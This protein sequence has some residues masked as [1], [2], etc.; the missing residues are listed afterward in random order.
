MSFNTVPLG[1]SSVTANSFPA[2]VVNASFLH[3][4]WLASIH[5]CLP[6]RPQ[7]QHTKRDPESSDKFDNFLKLALLTMAETYYK[8]K[9]IGITDFA[10]ILHAKKNQTKT[11]QMTQQIAFRTLSMYLS[12]KIRNAISK[13]KQKAEQTETSDLYLDNVNIEFP[14]PPPPPLP[15]EAEAFQIRFSLAYTILLNFGFDGKSHIMFS[16]SHW[17]DDN[18]FDYYPGCASTEIFD[19]TNNIC[20]PIICEPGHQVVHGS[21][22]EIKGEVP[23]PDEDTDSMEDPLRDDIINMVILKA[24]VTFSDFL[25]AMTPDFKVMMIESLSKLL[26][27]SVDRIQNFTV[28]KSETPADPADMII[29]R[30]PTKNYKMF[31]IPEPIMDKYSSTNKTNMKKEEKFLMEISFILMPLNTTRDSG[32]SVS[33]IIEEM[34]SLVQSKDFLLSI[35]ETRVTVVGLRNESHADMSY[36]W[37]KNGI[38]RFFNDSQFSMVSIENHGKTS[39]MIYINETNRLYK[40]GEFDLTIFVRSKIGYNKANVTGF[41]FVCDK[42]HIRNKKCGRISLNKGEYILYGNKSVNFR[43]HTL[44][45][46]D[47]QLSSGGSIVICIPSTMKVHGSMIKGCDHGNETLLYTQ[48]ILTIVFGILSLIA[49]LAVLITYTL[50]SKLRNIPGI[51]MMNLTLAL[52]GADLIFLVFSS[53]ESDAVCVTVAVSLHYLFLASFFWMNVMSYDLFRTFGHINVLPTP[54][55]KSKVIPRYLLYAWGAPLCIVAM[56]LVIEFGHIFPSV[57]IGYGRANPT[58]FF[59]KNLTQGSFNQSLNRTYAS[60]GTPQTSHQLGCWIQ[61]PSASLIAFGIP[62][63]IIILSNVVMFIRTIYC[64][65]RNLKTIHLN[66][67]HPVSGRHDVILYVRMSVVMGFTWVL[68][69]ASS[70][71]SGGANPSDNIC[72]LLNILGIL[73]VIFNCS[74]GI[75]ICSVFVLNRRV[76]GLYKTLWAKLL[77]TIKH[78]D[79][80]IFSVST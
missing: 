6:S 14:P 38:K 49:L 29:R 63:S 75:F 23:P 52:F 18:Y 77:K 55:Q 32:K 50:F 71:I 8:K 79:P 41:V 31:I 56:C 12:R 34:D 33:S 24:N 53:V 4:V 68:G 17:E 1:S 26:N 59:G 61:D 3:C 45:I 28:H 27:T 65:R 2:P 51:N 11:Y 60:M 69:F 46:N 13:E 15:Q 30:V 73:F 66:I 42:P 74:Q 39:E 72:L 70:G 35:N 62:L 54:R 48:I 40:K 47:Y 80:S 10:R 67:N 78:R 16:D 57:S 21:C 20:R 36:M 58:G 5:V 7:N 25:T 76:F 9:P 37:C 64:I 43:H 22:E 44:G 19:S